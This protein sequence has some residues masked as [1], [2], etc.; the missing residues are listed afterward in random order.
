[1]KN[2]KLFRSMSIQR[3]ARLIALAVLAMFVIMCCL[4]SVLIR[5][6]IYQ[7]EE[8]HMQVTSLRLYNQISLN[9]EKTENFCVNIG[10]NEEIRALMGTDYAQMAELVSGATECLTRHQVL[11][12]MIEDI[13]LV[14]DR[15]HYSNVYRDEE[16]DRMRETVNGVPFA[17]LGFRSHGFWADGQ[18]PE[19]MV[20]AGDIIVESENIGTVVLSID[21]SGFFT[22]NDKDTSQ[23]YMIVDADKMLY[24]F[25]QPEAEAQEPYQ[26]WLGSGQPQQLRAGGYS[27]HS[28]YFEEMDCYLLS[29]LDIRSTGE[30][31]EYIQ[32]LVWGCILLSAVFCIL[33]F[34]L[35]TTG[36]VRPLGQFHETILQIRQTN[37]RGLK[38]DLHLE[39]CAEIT[40]LGSEFTG[41]LDDIEK[42]NR[43]IFQSAV[44]LYELKVQKQ[45]AELAYLRSQVD[46]HFLY[47]TLEVVRKMA[48]EKQA[49]EIAQMAVDMGHIFR[50]SAKGEDEV[51]L[52][53]E[54]AIIKSY[55]R[56]QQMRFAGKIEVFYFIPDEVLQLR[57]MKMLLQPIVE[58]SVFH[59]LEPKRGSGS[60]FIGARL[61]GDTLVLTVKDDGIGIVRE[62]LTELQRQL[63]EENADTSAHVG[64][65]NTNARIRLYYGRMYGIS[66]ESCPEDGTTVILRLPAQTAAGGS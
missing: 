19:L 4:I 26:L 36:I 33:F 37:Q 62:R 6:L 8:E 34:M 30:G 11:E 25:N 52:E 42:L 49:P 47:N 2:R 24:L 27:V 9:Y 38:T 23:M 45:E 63:A 60:L 31:T 44:D 35:L 7:N 1:M 16:L 64:V 22:G 21:A 40:E 17:W 12:P 65:L 50:Y 29:V 55:I 15:I 61:E 57:V 3:Q 51:T 53:E 5:Q 20:Y 13:S 59:G 10:E 41:M 32:L 66:I 39:G 56:I 54:I 14:N 48:L 18:K 43:K 28:Y 58:N 46:P